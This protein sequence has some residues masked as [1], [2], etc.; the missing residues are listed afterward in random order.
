MLREFSEMER[1][2]SPSSCIALVNGASA[3]V[4]L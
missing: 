3:T 1:E 4:T 2:L